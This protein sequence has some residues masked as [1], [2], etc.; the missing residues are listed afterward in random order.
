MDGISA[1]EL[2]LARTCELS[3]VVVKELFLEEH[4]ESMYET[5][6]KEEE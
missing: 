6:C 1:P 5:D 4:L 3:G 2:T